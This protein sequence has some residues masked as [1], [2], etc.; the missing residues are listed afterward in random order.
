MSLII[1]I[2]TYEIRFMQL[3]FSEQC[4][5]YKKPQCLYCTGKKCAI[6]METELAQVLLDYIIDINLDTIL[7]EKIQLDKIKNKPERNW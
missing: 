3:F 6:F 4:S 7:N 1:L 2:I 5:K